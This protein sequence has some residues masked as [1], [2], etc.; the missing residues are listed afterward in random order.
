MYTYGQSVNPMAGVT[1]IQVDTAFHDEITG[2]TYILVINEVLYFG[3]NLN[4]SLI[5][6]NHIRSYGVDMWENQFDK[7]RVLCISV[8]D[9]PK[10]T[11]KWTVCKSCL[12]Q[13]PP[14]IK[15]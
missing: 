9:E 13:E 6:S 2:I 4:H 14:P 7:D 11:I 8:N 5:N 15:N 12:G 10:I 3:S 1:T